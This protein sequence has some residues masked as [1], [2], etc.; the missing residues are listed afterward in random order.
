MFGGPGTPMV[1]EFCVTELGAL[2]G[3]GPMAARALV[4]DALD[5]RYRLPMLWKQVQAGQV[6]AWQARKVAEQ[7]RP[8]SWDAC[9]ELDAAISGFLGMMTWSRF[10]TILTAAILDADPELAKEREDR[11]RKA[12]DVWACDS[13]DGLK[14]LI[15]KAT[16]GDVV[17]FL[18]TVNRIADILALE[19]DTDPVGVR[20]S[21]AIGILA[22]PAQA[23]ALLAAHRHDPA[24][25]D[26]QEPASEEDREADR[27]DRPFDKLREQRN[28]AS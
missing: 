1:S 10:Q 6:R 15:A 24:A 2:Q 12:R 26:D 28:R 5:L 22:Q 23:L 16:S 4:A 9:V 25:A 8:L 14:T 19:G 18:A 3:T 13:D 17:W 11:A 21:K 27:E 7:T 20:R